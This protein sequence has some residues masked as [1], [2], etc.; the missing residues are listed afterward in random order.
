MRTVYPIGTTLYKPAQCWNGYTLVWRGKRVKLIDMNGRTVNLWQLDGPGT[1]DV[2][3]GVSRAR[4]LQSGNLLVQRGGMMD[5][6]SAIQEYDWEHTLVWD[7]THAYNDNDAF[8]GMHHDVFRKDNGNTLIICRV[9]VPEAYMT[10]VRDAVHKTMTLYVDAV[11][12]VNPERKIVWEWYSYEHLDLNYPQRTFADP[13]WWAGPYNNTPCDWTH[14]NTVQALP[15]NQWYDAGDERFKPG[16]VLV[17]PR[18]LDRLYIINRETKAVAWSYRGDYRGG[19]SGQHEPHM[20]EKGLPGAGNILVYDNGASPWRDLAHAGR[21]YA[22][23]INPVTKEVV[24]VYDNGEQ[25]HANFTSSTQRL[26][27]GNTLICESAGKRVFEVTV[28]GEIVWEYVEGSPRSYRYPYD[29]C[30]QTAALGTPKEVSVT[31]P[32]DFCIPPD[33]PLT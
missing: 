30:P 17:S 2:P 31:P 23:E 24:W 20:I 32:E 28:E 14:F 21:S 25:F 27:N 3:H 10:R 11:L 33:E 7:Y 29:H 6:D 8:L 15:E 1:G 5:K 9:P 13:G 26:G 18:T 12:E 16:N 4:L 19:L 22:L